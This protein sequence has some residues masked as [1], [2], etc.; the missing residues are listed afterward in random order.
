M[1]TATATMTDTTETAEQMREVAELVARGANR[2]ARRRMVRVAENADDHTRALLGEILRALESAPAVMVPRLRHLW[3]C[4]DDAG[5]ELVEACAPTTERRTEAAES[6][7]R[8]TRTASGQRRESARRAPRDLPTRWTAPR[9]RRPQS[10]T[11]TD[12]A[13]RRY[14][15]ER[16]D[17]AAATDEQS[18]YDQ[19]DYDLAAVP[20]MRGLPC[21]ACGVE[22][23]TRDQQRAHDDGLCEDCRED[24][25]SGVVLL[26]ATATRA[27]VLVA[28][29]DHIAATS[30]TPAE[31]DARLRRDWR[32]LRTTDRFTVTDWYARQGG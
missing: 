32:H 24:G 17:P 20:P 4:S 6:E 2:E 25:A 15:D 12:T 16:E 1:E 14:F 23:S 13:A 9:P 21:V 27:D 19:L 30:T 8:A 7:A 29:C 5:R 26:P 3:R 28:R 10:A 22:R 31:R 11:D 18:D